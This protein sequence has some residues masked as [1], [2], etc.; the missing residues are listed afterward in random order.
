M[1]LTADQVGE[2]ARRFATLDMTGWDDAAFDRALTHL[3]WRPTRAS[4]EEREQ[5]R[6]YPRLWDYEDFRP[7]CKGESHEAYDTGLGTGLGQMARH[8][9]D[10]GSE[11]SVPVGEGQEVFRQLRAALEEILGAPSIMRGPG[12]LLRWRHPVRLLE[13]E[14]AGDHTS[15]RVSPTDAVD[16]DEHLA[17]NWG[18]PEYVLEQIGY[19]QV[20]GRGWDW[21]PGGSWADDWP[22]FEERLATTLRSVVRDFALLDIPDR[23]TVV[24]CTPQD[25]RFVQ[26]TTFED[27]TLH[28]QARI[29]DD[30]D[31]GWS[32][33]M[34][35]L[36]WQPPDDRALEGLLVRD[37][38]AF[39]W[40]HANTA[41][42]MLV[43]ALRSYDVPFEDLWHEV[44]SPDVDLLGIG[45]PTKQGGRI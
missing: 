41:A 16:R 8:G 43:A 3:G 44:I 7:G 4:A 30:P 19:W 15:L 38:P 6:T 5:S 25:R 18:E 20:L 28:L 21:A 42:H 13:L 24:V 39:D 40:Q 36:G 27:Q 14:H 12:P 2:L 31:P 26:W 35:E 45:L 32:E 1:P 23:F 22:E 33:A 11:I 10:I 29:P 37:F 9:S 34:A 17:S